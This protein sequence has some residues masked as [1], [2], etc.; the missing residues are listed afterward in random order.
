MKQYNIRPDGDD[1]W[2]TNTHLCREHSSSRS[3]PKTQ[4]LAAVSEGTIIGPVL[5]VHVVKILDGSEIEVAIP[6]VAN[7]MDTSY[8]VN[9]RETE[10][11]VNEIHDHKKELKSSNELL[12]KD[13]EEMTYE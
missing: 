9:S 1:G 12:F 2:R 11:F 8:V 3:Y 13:Q 4:A 10:R 5:E 7:S 6:S